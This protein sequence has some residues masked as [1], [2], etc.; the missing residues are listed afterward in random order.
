MYC[1]AI[2]GTGAT[3]AEFPFLVMEEPKSFTEFQSSFLTPIH[4]SRQDAFIKV[5]QALSK[6][7]CRYVSQMCRSVRWHTC[8]GQSSDMYVSGSTCVDQ[9]SGTCA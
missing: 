3:N 4:F 7:V 6:A 1:D 5:L 8:V 9:S 2:S